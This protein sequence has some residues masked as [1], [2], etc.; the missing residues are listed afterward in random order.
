MCSYKKNSNEPC[1]DCPRVISA[2]YMCNFLKEIQ[3]E[4]TNSKYV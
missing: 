1:K 2:L 3:N 4:D